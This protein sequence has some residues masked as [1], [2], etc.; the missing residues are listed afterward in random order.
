[1]V[2]TKQ[3]SSQLEWLAGLE[4]TFDP[5]DP[6]EKFLRKVSRISLKRVDPFWMMMC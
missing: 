3:V 5:M 6:N 4:A 1:M 2:V